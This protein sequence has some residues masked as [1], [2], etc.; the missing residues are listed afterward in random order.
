MV[1]QKLIRH[2][3]ATCC[4]GYDAFRFSSPPFLMLPL[5]ALMLRLMMLNMIRHATFLAAVDFHFFFDFFFFARWLRYMLPMLLFDAAAFRRLRCCYRYADM[6]AGAM[7]PLPLSM[8][9][10]DFHAPCDTLPHYA[11]RGYTLI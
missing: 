2:A 9:S 4:Y 8:F 1:I 10:S 6:A 7:T 11:A 5:I 3:I